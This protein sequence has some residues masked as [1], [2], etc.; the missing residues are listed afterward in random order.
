[1]A[2]VELP[3]ITFTRILVVALVLEEFA[4]LS[5]ARRTYAASGSGQNT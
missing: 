1:V 5:E 2:I 3:A 4:I